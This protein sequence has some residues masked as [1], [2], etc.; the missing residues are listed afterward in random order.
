MDDYGYR[1][2]CLSVICKFGSLGGGKADLLKLNN[3]LISRNIICIN[4]RKKDVKKSISVTFCH[5]N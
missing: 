3:Y 2:D 1:G 4:N 5:R